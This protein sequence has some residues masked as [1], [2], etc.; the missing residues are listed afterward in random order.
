MILTFLWL[1]NFMSPLQGIKTERFEKRVL[2]R[3]YVF[4]MEG[5]VLLLGQ[6]T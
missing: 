5:L 4:K 1:E 2:G 6:V 3:L